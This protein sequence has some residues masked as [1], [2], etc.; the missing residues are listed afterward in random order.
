MMILYRVI[1]KFENGVKSHFYLLQQERE[2]EIR[3][4]HKQK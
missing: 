4:K 2:K 1:E 3:S